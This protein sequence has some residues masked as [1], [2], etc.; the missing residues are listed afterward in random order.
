[1]NIRLRAAGRTASIF[2]FGLLGGL[3]AYAA[4]Q[5]EPAMIL[6]LIV[7]LTFVWFVYLVYSINLRN[8]EDIE[9]IDE[10]IRQS[11]NR[12]ANTTKGEK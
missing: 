8:L 10:M 3:L 1:M 12:L 2:V 5:F 9:M 11:E 6:F 7:M 4:F